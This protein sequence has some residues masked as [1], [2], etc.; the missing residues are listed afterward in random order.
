MAWMLGWLSPTLQLSLPM[1]IYSY[2]N[3]GIFV[4][5]NHCVL[6]KSTVGMT[7]KQRYI[8]AGPCVR[9]L[10][11]RWQ[12]PWRDVYRLVIVYSK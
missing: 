1:P 2:K 4:I 9:H 12:I 8:Y 3:Y 6:I 10:L 5:N 7:T 11:E